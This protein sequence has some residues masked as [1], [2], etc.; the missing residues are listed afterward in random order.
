LAGGA[1]IH[2]QIGEY[3]LEGE[4][5]HPLR[6]LLHHRCR[7]ADHHGLPRL[8]AISLAKIE[9]KQFAL[10]PT[11]GRS[12]GKVTLYAGS[13]HALFDVE[14]K[15]INV[16]G[17]AVIGGT[18]VNVTGEPVSFSN[19]NRVWGGAAQARPMPIGPR[20]FLD[21]AFTFARSEEFKINNSASFSNSNGPLTSSGVAFLNTREQITNQSVVLTLNRQF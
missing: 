11:I 3:R 9:L 16:V 6:G 21:L 15:F 19:D 13:G 4:R 8:R 17:F 18:L 12:F 20:W 1:Q 2:L 14:T 10:I 7:P 5:E